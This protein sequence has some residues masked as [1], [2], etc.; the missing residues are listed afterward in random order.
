VGASLWRVATFKS[1]LGAAHFTK[2][3]IY[4][5]SFGSLI[6]ENLCECP[7]IYA[8]HGLIGF[9]PLGV[10]SNIAASRCRPVDR[11][12]SCET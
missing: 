11:V 10:G 8:E 12:Y 7:H 5:V 6:S 1:Y 4:L 9:E 2:F 3:E